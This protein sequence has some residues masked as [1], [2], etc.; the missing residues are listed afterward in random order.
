MDE[1]RE[2]VLRGKSVDEVGELLVEVHLIDDVDGGGVEDDDVE[3]RWRVE[4]EVVAEGVRGGGCGGRDDGG[5]RASVLLEGG[6]V[7]WL[8]V[9]EDMKVGAA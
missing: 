7:L 2:R 6:D 9:V 1:D 4:Q 8:F 3:D 5:L